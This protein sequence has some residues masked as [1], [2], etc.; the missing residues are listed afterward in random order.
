MLEIREAIV[1]EGK[2]DKVALGSVVDTD[3][4]VTD[5]FG[6]FNDTFA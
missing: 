5:G 1:V 3:I 4:F 6:I 2:Y